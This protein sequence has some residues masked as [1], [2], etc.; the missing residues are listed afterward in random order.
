M[1]DPKA[2]KKWLLL[3]RAV[4]DALYVGAQYVMGRW[5]ANRIYYAPW[6]GEFTT[7]VAEH[8]RSARVDIERHLDACF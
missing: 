2:I 6:G 8:R 4:T 5:L 7:R 3:E 1:K